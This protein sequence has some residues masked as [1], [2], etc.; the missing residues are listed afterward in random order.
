MAASSFVGSGGSIHVVV[1]VVVIVVVAVVVV[2]VVVAVVVVVVVVVIVVIVVIVVVAVVAVVVVVVVVSLSLSF[3]V[4][5]DG[6]ASSC[7]YECI[8][9][10]GGGRRTAKCS[11][12]ECDKEIK[13]NK[14]NFSLEQ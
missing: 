2:V 11:R 5:F 4:V 6:S 10:P 8:M 7:F 1:V 3:V 12:A 9:K 14:N 13:A